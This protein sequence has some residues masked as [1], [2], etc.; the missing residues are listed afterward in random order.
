MKVYVCL[1]VFSD[2][3][4]P[5]E[6]RNHIGIAGDETWK[7]GDKR[8]L[9]EILEKENGWSLCS[10]LDNNLE[11]EAHIYQIMGV[12]K[13]GEDKLKMLSERDDCEVQLSCAIYCSSEPALFLEKKIISW[14]N[15][16][17]ASLD[18]DLYIS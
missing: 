11:L 5:E 16:I 7:V 14:I 4:S 13:G 2:S 1:T 15:S 12:T 3:L 10:E 8:G 9:T 18:I 17:G 6:M